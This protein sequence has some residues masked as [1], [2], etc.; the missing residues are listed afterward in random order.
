ML[1]IERVQDVPEEFLREHP[2]GGDFYRAYARAKVPGFQLG[3]FIVRRDGRPI[4]AAPFFVMHLPL[5]TMMPPGLLKNLMGS[6]ALKTAFIGHPSADVGQIQGESSPEVLELVHAE[7]FKL[8]SLI[9]Y[10]GFEKGLSLPGFNKVIGL[11]VP[12]LKV[13]ADYW[14]QLKHKVRTDLKRKLKAS[15]GLLL[16]EV[17]GLPTEYL[18]PVYALYRQTADNA[19]IQF[20]QLNPEY[21]IETGSLSKYILYF[22]GE[23]M[24]G[25][26]QLMCNRHTMYCKYIGMDRCSAR[27]KLY[28]ALMIQAVNIAI[29]EGIEQVDFGVTSYAFK[30]HLGSEMHDT[31]NFFRHRR[32]IVNAVLKRVGFL[33]EPDESELL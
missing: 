28:F 18:K 14:T 2:E 21:F 16:I 1:S 23:T 4:T 26:H 30:R 6:L 3:C 19:D 5:N 31:Y 33:L 24:I 22:E 15:A 20:E 7:L 11:P 27:Y 17:D 12:V 13:N 9:A 32:P 25:F 29:R 8:S 10:K